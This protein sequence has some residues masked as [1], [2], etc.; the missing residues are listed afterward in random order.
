MTM[1]RQH[2]AFARLSYGIALFHVKHP[3][4]SPVSRETTWQGGCIVF[5]H[6]DLNRPISQNEERHL[7]NGFKCNYSISKYPVFS[8]PAMLGTYRLFPKKTG[9]VATSVDKMV[10][11]RRKENA[12]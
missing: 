11:P 10:S 3:A 5:T 7:E 9:L 2:R 8:I 12:K 1:M 6:S 4:A